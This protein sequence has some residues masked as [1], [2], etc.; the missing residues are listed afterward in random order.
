[1]EYVIYSSSI[2]INT[3]PICGLIKIKS[4]FLF[5]DNYKGG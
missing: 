2:S 4:L 3:I 5:G 1:M